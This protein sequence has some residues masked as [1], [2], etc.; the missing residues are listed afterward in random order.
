VAR[1]LRVLPE[2]ELRQVLD[3]ERLAGLEPA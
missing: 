3:L 1:R 2:E